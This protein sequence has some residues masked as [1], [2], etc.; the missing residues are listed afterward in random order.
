ML[1]D[2]AGQMHDAGEVLGV[3]YERLTN[4]ARRNGQPR[5][6]ERIFGLNVQVC[7]SIVLRNKSGLV[8]A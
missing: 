2:C 8:I 7:L 1:R 6:L 3:L 5:M 4:V